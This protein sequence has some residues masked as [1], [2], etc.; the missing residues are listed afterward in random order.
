MNKL[1]L[2]SIHKTL[3]A[4]FNKKGSKNVRSIKIHTLLEELLEGLTSE[5]QED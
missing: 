4:I 3:I 5:T 2:I 1:V